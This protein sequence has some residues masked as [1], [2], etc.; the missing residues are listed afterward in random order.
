MTYILYFIFC[1]LCMLY[2]L[3]DGVC[4]VEHNLMPSA[5]NYGQDA[6]FFCLSNLAWMTTFLSNLVFVVLVLIRGISQSLFSA[7]LGL[8]L[9]AAGLYVLYAGL[10]G[11]YYCSWAK[12]LH[13]GQSRFGSRGILTVTR[14]PEL[15]GTLLCLA[16]MGAGARSWIFD[17]TL[18]I[19]AVLICLASAGKERS[20]LEGNDEDSREYDAYSERTNFLFGR[21][22][23]SISD[24]HTEKTHIAE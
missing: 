8:V 15:I 4:A 13:D 17:L 6:G 22:K 10:T 24:I 5:Y 18:L 11:R 14:N 16:G 3:A 12:K 9:F 21:K 1:A 2:L 20:I 19:P 23:Y 7:M